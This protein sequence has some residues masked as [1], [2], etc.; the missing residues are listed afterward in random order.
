M[1]R[2]PVQIGTLHICEAIQLATKEER[3]ALPVTWKTANFPPQVLA[4][5]GILK[6]P[7]FDLN[8]FTTMGPLLISCICM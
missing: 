5:A 3:E 4:K 2:V 1:N 8:L 6:E 7:E